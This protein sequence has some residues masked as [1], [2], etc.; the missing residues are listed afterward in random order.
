M[1]EAADTKLN[2]IQTFSQLTEQIKEVN[3]E[4]LSIDG[5]M[6]KIIQKG[7]FDY[8][9]PDDLVSKQNSSST[10]PCTKCTVTLNHLQIHEN[11][12][13][14]IEDCYSDGNIEKNIEK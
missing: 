8:L 3:D 5:K 10:F 2:N 7:V 12:E 13:H 4:I 11:K 6:F 14:S 1:Y 9:A